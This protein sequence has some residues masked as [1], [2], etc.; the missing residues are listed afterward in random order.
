MTMMM[1]CLLQSC[2]HAV[3]RAANCGDLGMLCAPCQA[4]AGTPIDKISLRPSGAERS[5]I[6]FSFLRKAGTTSRRVAFLKTCD[7]QF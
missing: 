1:R 5:V 2:K 3:P 4:L 7:R 6:S